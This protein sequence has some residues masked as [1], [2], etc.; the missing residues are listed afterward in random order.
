MSEL[1]TSTEHSLAGADMSSAGLLIDFGMVEKMN[2]L[3]KLMA[4]SKIAVPP[5]FRGQAGDC[6]AVVM[7][8]A[9][10]G[11]NPFAVA[12]KCFNVNGV[13]GYEAQLVSAVVNNRAPIR[14]RLKYEWFGDWSKILGRFVERESKT[15]KDDNGYAIKYRVPGWT[16]AD[17]EGL[18]VRVWTTLKGEDEPRVLEL[19]M[20][21]ARTRN[22]TLWADDPKQQLA[23]LATKRWARLYCPDVLLGVYTPDELEDTAPPKAVDMGRADEVRKEA[24]GQATTKTD[25]LRSRMA[26]K[27]PT[28]ATQA[29]PT[30]DD[31]VK[32]IN[33]ATTAH[34][35]KAAISRVEE[36]STDADKGDVRAAYQEKLRTEK[37][38]V[39]RETAAQTE[40]PQQQD[41]GAP[42]LAPY[43][44][45]LS[46][47]QQCNDV[48]VLDVL[49]D[50]ARP[51]P[52]P[53]RIKLEQA[54]QDRREILLGA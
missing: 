34:E 47:M 46:R 45:M 50:E 39:Q 8:S 30:A 24:D 18:G 5:H 37:E 48:N 26:S 44:T 11:M 4:T 29:P 9:Q 1:L 54:Y 20:T 31:M 38:R 25:T 12:Q 7:Q 21:Q 16:I 22:S 32:A 13:L 53:D 6:L 33:A 49:A 14:E 36:L 52:E 23:Y 42:P 28:S 19:L 3:A 40:Q 27:R 2:D 17:E 15:K 41:G 51:Y 10:W 43:E 35:L